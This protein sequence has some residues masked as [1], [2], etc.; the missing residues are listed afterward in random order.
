MLDSKPSWFDVRDD[1]EQFPELPPVTYF[2]PDAT[3]IRR[4]PLMG[5]ANVGI[6]ARVY[7]A[8]RT[9][10]HPEVFAL[11]HPD[12]EIFQSNEVP[13][14]GVYRG[15]EGVGQFFAK[16]TGKITSTVI[17]ERYVDAGDQVVAIG[18]TRGSTNEGDRRFDVRIAHVWTL[19]DGGVSRVEYYIDDPTMLAVL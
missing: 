15:H 6:V 4:D 2:L 19:R 16:L 7:D 1:A 9:R 10:K 5:R 3:L 12:I 11:L 17:I 18:R 13:W 14:G 8:F